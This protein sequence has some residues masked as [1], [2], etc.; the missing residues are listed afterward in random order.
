MEHGQIFTILC[1][2]TGSCELDRLQVVPKKTGTEQPMEN[3][4]SSAVCPSWEKEP[5]SPGCWGPLL[6]L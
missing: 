5:P 4:N 1:G 6:P 3:R 2:V